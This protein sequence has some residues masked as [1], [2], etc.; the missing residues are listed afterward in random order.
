MRLQQNLRHVPQDMQRVTKIAATKHSALGPIPFHGAIRDELIGMQLPMELLS[1]HTYTDSYNLQPV[2]LTEC[3]HCSGV[4]R[5]CDTL[6]SRML[7]GANLWKAKLT[8]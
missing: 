1:P 3:P 5:C 8:P 7:K 6:S 2:E 4:I